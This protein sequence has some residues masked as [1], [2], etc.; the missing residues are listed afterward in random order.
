MVRRP[1]HCT[2]SWFYEE[3][4]IVNYR[5]DFIIKSPI[6]RKLT[7]KLLSGGTYPKDVGTEVI[8]NSVSWYFRTWIYKIFLF[9][10]HKRSRGSRKSNESSI[11]GMW[12]FSINPYLAYLHEEI[13]DKWGKSHSWST[14]GRWRVVKGTKLFI[15][16]KMQRETTINRRYESHVII[17]GHLRLLERVNTTIQFFMSQRALF[18]RVKT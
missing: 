1:A 17:L 14:M 15:I 18:S 16:P 11:N 7:H 9:T 6:W 10:T 13:C 3:T 12:S 8:F 5:I 4:S 2:Q